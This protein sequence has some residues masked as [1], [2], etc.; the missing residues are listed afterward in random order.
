M[1]MLRGEVAR[2]SVL[3][4]PRIAEA[5]EEFCL[6]G[7]GARPECID[8]AEGQ[9]NGLLLGMEALRAQNSGLFW[10]LFKWHDSAGNPFAY[11]PRRRWHW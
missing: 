5:V 7:T 8:W 10:S 9:V 11:A 1:G 3:P 2:S 4:V 6:G